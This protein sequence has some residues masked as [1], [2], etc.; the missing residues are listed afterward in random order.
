MRFVYSKH[1][2][3]RFVSLRRYDGM[4][5]TDRLLFVINPKFKLK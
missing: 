2:G 4:A 5:Y 3:Y 1:K